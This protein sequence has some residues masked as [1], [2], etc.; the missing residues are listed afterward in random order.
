[1]VASGVPLKLLQQVTANKTTGMVLTHYYQP[2]R[3]AFR[4]GL[5]TAMPKL[6]TNGQQSPKEAM[7]VIIEQGTPKT[8]KRDQPRLLELPNTV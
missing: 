6:T 7:R 5:Q 2:G 8:W 1:V 4:Q 3:E